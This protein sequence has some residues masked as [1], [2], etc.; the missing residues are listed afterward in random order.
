MKRLFFLFISFLPLLLSAQKGSEVMLKKLE[1]KAPFG[2]VKIK[3]PDFNKCTRLLITD[4]G[5]VKG[6][7]EKTATAIANAIN[8]A[9]EMGGGV[10]V[11]PE[12]EWLTKKNPF[13]KQCCA[14]S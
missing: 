5:A 10:V 6:D 7:K 1:V 8:K 13:Q 2:K 9:N 11:I 14:A 3:E 4:F 12:G